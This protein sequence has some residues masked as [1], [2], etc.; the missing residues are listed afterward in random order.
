MT[1][2]FGQP[3]APGLRYRHRPGAYAVLWRDGQ[4]LLTHQHAP[5]PEFQ[6]PGGGIDP[7]ESPLQALHREVREETGWSLSGARLIGSY[8]RF[9]YMPDYGF[10]AEKL[11][12]VW[13]A[14]PAMRLSDPTEPGHEAHWMTPARAL[15]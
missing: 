6:L 10:H 11:C 5:E 8:R 7:G 13:L 2:R 12:T 15:A 14:R 4:I 9:C 1:P 3:P